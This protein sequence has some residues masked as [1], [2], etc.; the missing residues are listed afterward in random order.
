MQ[1]D[2]RSSKLSHQF[3]A[4][5]RAKPQWPLTIVIVESDKSLLIEWTH[6][7]ALTR[8]FT[9]KT[10][11]DG[12][13]AL[14]KIVEEMP[15]LIVTNLELPH[16]SGAEMIR[17]LRQDPQYSHVAIVTL[18]NREEVSPD[19]DCPETR[20]CMR[21]VKPDTGEAFVQAMQDAIRATCPGL[22]AQA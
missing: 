21:I 15:D 17:I 8:K 2:R 10:A 14:L 16:L 1:A 19:A 12:F 6:A 7:L 11:P 9:V 3:A 5:S 22:E 4:L 13:S 18:A 20:K